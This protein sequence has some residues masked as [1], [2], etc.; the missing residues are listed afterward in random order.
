MTKEKVTVLLVDDEPRL[1]EALQRGLEAQGFTVETAADGITGQALAESGTYDVIVLDVMM[2]GRDGLEVC[3]R[4]RNQ[5]NETPILI[6][7]ARDGDADQIQ[8]LRAGADDYLTKPFHYLV[9][10]ERLRALTR[11]VRSYESSNSHGKQAS[12]QE[13]DAGSVLVVGELS[14]IPDQ[15]RARRSNVE[16]EL[17]TK[18]F[19]ILAYLAERPGS[20]ISKEELIDELWE[21]RAPRDLNAVEVHIS[22][23]R[24]QLDAPFETKLLRTV[25]GSGY[26]LASEG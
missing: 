25:R 10:V 15:R 14:V 23:L 11:R 24:R 16:L 26:R 17:T 9:L 20:V 2:P 7:T 8:G 5:G 13:A 22:S 6:L 4:L 1:V 18:E 19:D 12:G 3:R 21:S